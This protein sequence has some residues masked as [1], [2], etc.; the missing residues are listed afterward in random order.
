MKKGFTLIELTIV[1]AITAILAGIVL[2]SVQQYIK[3]GKDA[4][5]AGNIA[6][7]IPSGEAWYNDGNTYADFC[8]PSGN[9]VIKNAISQMPYNADGPCFDDV[10]IASWDTNEDDGNP[11]GL[12]CYVNA[13]GDEWVA[14]IPKFSDTDKAFCVD[15]RG[16][17]KEIDV[18]DCG[19]S[20]IAGNPWEC[21]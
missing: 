12:C 4:N 10:P 9:S 2:F 15:S 16:V 17:Q 11:A 19:S 7:L 6:I 14:C 8:D 21:P 18:G 1:L 20:L 13:G 3:I 5:V